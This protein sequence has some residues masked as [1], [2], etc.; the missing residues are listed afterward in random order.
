MFVLL[1]LPLFYT[2]RVTCEPEICEKLRVLLCVSFLDFLLSI[3]SLPEL[4]FLFS[5]FPL[6]FVIF[7]ILVSS[8]RHRVVTFI[9]SIF[10]G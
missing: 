1:L 2:P 8:F 4:N 6:G 5:P 10:S 7:P 9:L 3:A